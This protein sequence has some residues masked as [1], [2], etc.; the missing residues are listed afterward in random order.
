M[1]ILNRLNPNQKEA[2]TKSDGPLLILAGAGSGKTRVITHKIAYL[3]KNRGIN[4]SHIIAL[5]FTNKAAEEMKERVKILLRNSSFNIWIS[6]FHSACARILRSEIERLGYSNDFIIY[7]SG[8]SLELIK[9]CMKKLDIFDEL[10]QSKDILNK[11]SEQK[12]NLIF[13]EAYHGNDFGF[14][15]HVKKIYLLYQRALY[16]NNALDFDDLL[17]LTIKLFEKNLDI[18]ESYQERFRYILVDEYQDTNYS[19]FYLLNLLAKKYRNICVVGDDDQS[20]YHWRG[21]N[22]E[23][24]LNFEKDYPDTRIVTLEENYRSTKTI[25]DAA[26]EIIKKNEGRKDKKL[27]TNNDKG[28]KIIYF[29]A[30]D[31]IKESDYI[32]S[33]IKNLCNNGKMK[34]KDFAIFFRTN[35]Q[36]RVIEDSLRKNQIPYT[37]VK[38][39]RFYERKEIKEILAYIK[40]VFNPYDSVSLKRIINIPARGIGKVTLNKIDS[41]IK[42][43]EI[44]FFEGIDEM[45]KKNIV[46]PL[47]ERRLE[48]FFKLIKEL[49]KIGEKETVFRLV[50]EILNKTKYLE[51]LE[52]KNKGETDGRLD[53]VKEFISAIKEFERRTEDKSLKAFLDYS[54]LVSE[55][56]FIDE[57]AGVVSL[58]TLHSSKGL[59]FPLV[60]ISG[61]ENGLFPHA[62]A[63]ETMEELEEERRLCYVGMT[64]AKDRLFLTNC[65]RRNIYG[66]Y[67]YNFPSLFLKDIPDKYISK[68][69]NETSSSHLDFYQEEEEKKEDSLVGKKVCHPKF[70][71]G[72]VSASEGEEEN[73]KLTVSFQGFGKRKLMAKYASLKGL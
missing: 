32:A 30:D 27:W 48:K 23:N 52:K 65:I 56:D 46:A 64:R 43:R 41:Y 49:K 66:N 72:V 17:L 10:Y 28:E 31:E 38:G 14:E 57:D 61:M 37:I 25:L 44:S 1:D 71:V 33:T 63:F 6:T 34:F 15:Q 42:E 60:F 35:A 47:I 20:I 11:I 13:P 9:E 19:Q 62:K 53:N 16:N 73:L 68:A 54:V 8:D 45:I 58:I 5:T 50:K 39:L 12:R 70:G 69:F 55:T 40:V 4:P 26:A 24:I 21:A 7:D 59:E 22:L 18:L 3:I 67:Q 2:V 51:T 29:R 36:S